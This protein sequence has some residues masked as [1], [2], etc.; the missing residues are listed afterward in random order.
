MVLNGAEKL[1]LAQVCEG[2]IL[3]VVDATASF[4]PARLGFAE[5]GCRRVMGKH[6]LPEEWRKMSA[7]K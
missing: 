4:D 5:R 1:T 6:H 3:H 7:A 2:T